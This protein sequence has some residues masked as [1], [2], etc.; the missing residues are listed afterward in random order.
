MTKDVNEK[1]DAPLW[2]EIDAAMADCAP[3]AE[4][5]Q[6]EL[7]KVVDRFGL[8]DEEQL[9]SDPFGGGMFMSVLHDEAR[10]EQQR[11]E[12]ARRRLDAAIEAC[13][14]AWVPGRK[15][16]PGWMECDGD[17]WL[18]RAPGRH[19]RPESR[20]PQISCE[21]R[22]DFSRRPLANLRPPVLRDNE[23]VRWSF[24]S[25]IPQI[26]K[27]KAPRLEPDRPEPFP[28]FDWRRS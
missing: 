6:R 9:K 27:G 17:G 15:V 18:D 28:G 21:V 5:G 26:V 10:Y 2:T 25:P 20:R 13:A 19:I 16:P 7:L 1:G 3:Q 23:E 22:D 4:R 14:S 8:R 12:K 11:R 24:A